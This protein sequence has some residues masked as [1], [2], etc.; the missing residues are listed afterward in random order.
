MKKK[1][2]I[3]YKEDG[4]G[5]FPY[6][7]YIEHNLDG[8]EDSS[9]WWCSNLAEGVSGK[10]EWLVKHYC[11]P[12]EVEIVGDAPLLRENKEFMEFLENEILEVKG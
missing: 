12:D 5:E 7:W 4:G 11:R 1:I 2:K 9:S 3:S 8:K 10:L 6:K